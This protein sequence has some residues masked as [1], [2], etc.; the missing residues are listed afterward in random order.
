MKK[1]KNR[2]NGTERQETNSHITH[3]IYRI[4]RKMVV[5]LD[6][7]VKY[8]RVSQ[9]PAMLQTNHS[10]HKRRNGIEMKRF[11]MEKKE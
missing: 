5:Q 3:S 11:C 2:A 6:D 8:D 10:S 1:Q 9:T 4:G 7:G